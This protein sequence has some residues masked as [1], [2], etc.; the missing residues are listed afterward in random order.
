MMLTNLLLAHRHVKKLENQNH[1][2]DAV[3]KVNSNDDVSEVSVE[4]KKAPEKEARN[5]HVPAVEISHTLGGKASVDE[6]SG[7]I[8]EK[9]APDVPPSASLA[10]QETALRNERSDPAVQTKPSTAIVSADSARVPMKKRTAPD[11]NRPLNEYLVSELELFSSCMLG[12]KDSK[13]MTKT[14]RVARASTLQLYHDHTRAL[15]D[16]DADWK[17]YVQICWRT[18]ALSYR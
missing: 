15:V 3:L 16:F 18:Y 7:S 10:Q 11:E 4:K 8:D 17:R 2:A 14:N 9:P 6:K 12:K 1:P 13:E 5:G